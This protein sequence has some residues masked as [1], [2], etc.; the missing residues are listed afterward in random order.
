MRFV[1]YGIILRLSMTVE[2]HWAT[3]I[4]SN[5]SSTDEHDSDG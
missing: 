2:D 3:L 5:T 4:V 1:T